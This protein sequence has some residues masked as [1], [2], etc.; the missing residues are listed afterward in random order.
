M[1]DEQGKKQAVKIIIAGL[2]IQLALVIAAVIWG[3]IYMRG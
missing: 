3:I 2:I 1:N